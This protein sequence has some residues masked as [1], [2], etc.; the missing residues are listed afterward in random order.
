MPIFATRW[1]PV[2][3]Q[4]A[5]ISELKKHRHKGN[6]NIFSR[7]KICHWIKLFSFK[8]GG[9]YQTGNLCTSDFIQLLRNHHNECGNSSKGYKICIPNELYNSHSYMP[10][11]PEE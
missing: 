4:I 1:Y 6:R 9:V 2:L 8:K 3:W 7:T 11:F 5:K 10:L